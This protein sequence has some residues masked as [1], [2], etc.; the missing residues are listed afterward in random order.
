MAAYSDI[1]VCLSKTKTA[2][3][4][5]AE[6]SHGY[7]ARRRRTEWIGSVRHDVE[8]AALDEEN[9][10]WIL[11]ATCADHFRRF[12]SSSRQQHQDWLM[13]DSQMTLL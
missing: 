2:R 5:T 11:C 8:I 9:G 1:V 12:V 10:E 7:E 4:E 3:M 6:A 13:I